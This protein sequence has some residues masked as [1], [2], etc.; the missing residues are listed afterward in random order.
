VKN[1]KH[2][3][4]MTDEEAIK[5]LFN[6]KIRRAIHKHLHGQDQALR[7]SKAKSKKTE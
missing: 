5:H 6:P 3:K 1:V 4:D 2:P 7:P